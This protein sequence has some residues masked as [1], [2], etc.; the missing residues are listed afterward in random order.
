[1]EGVGG[2]PVEHTLLHLN[3]SDFLKR[4]MFLQVLYVFII[5]L[6]YINIVVLGEQGK[7][8]ILYS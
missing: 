7:M 6:P 4:K 2:A 1:M 5:K 8:N 3:L